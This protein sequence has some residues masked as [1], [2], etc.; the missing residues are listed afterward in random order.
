MQI[1]QN[2][3]IFLKIFSWNG[4]FSSFLKIKFCLVLFT[5]LSAL[6]DATKIFKTVNTLPER[7]GWK[8]EEKKWTIK[9]N[10]KTEYC[11]YLK[12]K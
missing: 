11:Q 4:S 2:K 6:W 3:L 8:T 10:K 12:I 5:S 7:T 9:V 1:R